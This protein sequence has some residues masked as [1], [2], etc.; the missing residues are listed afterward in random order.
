MRESLLDYLNTFFHVYHEISYY[1]TSESAS[2]KIITKEM[3]VNKVYINSFLKKDNK[4][5]MLWKPLS[6]CHSSYTKPLWC[7]LGSRQLE[8]T[9]KACI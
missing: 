4:T 9:L 7:V 5:I 1:M 3:T 8:I 6:P 2:I